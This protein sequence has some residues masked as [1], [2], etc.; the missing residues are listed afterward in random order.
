MGTLKASKLK[1][2]ST[3]NFFSRTGACND[4]AARAIGYCGVIDQQIE[5]LKLRGFAKTRETVD[6]TD[7]RIAGTQY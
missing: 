6:L 3:G 1:V 4:E 2:G 7:V 5:H